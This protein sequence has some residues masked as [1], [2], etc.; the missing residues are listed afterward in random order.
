VLAALSFE[1]SQAPSLGGLDDDDW[2]AALAFC[3]RSHLTLVPGERCEAELPPWVRSR[4]AGNLEANRRRIARLRQEYFEIQ[5]R[6]A[7]VNVPHIL[8]KG[9]THAPRFVPKAELRPQTD[10]DLFVASAHLES[11][12]EI[13]LGLGFEAGGGSS[14]L[15]AD[16][17]P[18]FIRK[19]GWQWK[20][21]YFD[22]DIPPVVELHF[23]LWDAATECFA[24]EG[25]DLFPGR[26]EALE[27]DGGSVPSLSAADQFGYAC[28]HVLRHLLRGD[29]KAFHV[30]EIACFLHGQAESESLWRDWTAAHSDS[31]RRLEAISC[32]L[33]ARWFGCR[34]PHAVEREAGLLPA[35]LA[36]WIAAYAHAPVAA[37]FSP[38]K[39][40]LWLHLSLLANWRD[41]LRVTRRRLAPLSLPGHVD[42]VFVPAAELTPALRI[43]KWAAYVGFLARRLLFHARAL[44]STAASGL[45][46]WLKKGTINEL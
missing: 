24:A 30:Y 10:L 3:D 7:Q 9:F 8:L 43:R 27:V 46:W 22:P 37:L 23:R 6:L 15:R 39:H 29:L 31:L 34:L 17:L 5:R 16:H 14:S 42:A 25:V 45:L 2:R 26:S 12:A 33:A 13:L 4:I 21:D 1:R 44:L 28:L 32:A 40:E 20:G 38:N 18:P 41:R 11:A 36:R 19:T 35:P